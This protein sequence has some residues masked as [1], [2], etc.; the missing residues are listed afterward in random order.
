VTTGEGASAPEPTIMVGMTWDFGA[1]ESEEAMTRDELWN[2]IQNGREDLTTG[3]SRVTALNIWVTDAV[4]C[5]FCDHSPE[6]HIST[7]GPCQNQ[8]CLCMEYIAP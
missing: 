1:Y 4:A 2:V 3:R 7:Y 6:Q 8:G 5:D